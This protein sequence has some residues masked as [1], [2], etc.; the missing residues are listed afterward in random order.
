MVMTDSLKKLI[1][2]TRTLDQSAREREQQRRSFAYGN[3]KFENDRITREMVDRQA[4]L[5]D[6]NAKH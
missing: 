1:E 3:T 2:A 6:Q 4:E 5:L